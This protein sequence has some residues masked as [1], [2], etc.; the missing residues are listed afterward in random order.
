ME[1]WKDYYSFFFERIKSDPRIRMGHLAVFSGL[2]YLCACKEGSEEI[3]AFSKDVMILV[4]ISG[5]FTYYR[6]IAELAEYGYIK[7]IPSKS[8][9]YPSEILLLDH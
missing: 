9:F 8:K 3:K 2:F 6:I 5:P 7:Y 1:E 4:K